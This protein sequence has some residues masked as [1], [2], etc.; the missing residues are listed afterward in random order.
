MQ[1]PALKLRIRVIL[2]IVAAVAIAIVVTKKVDGLYR[3]YF[4]AR[5]LD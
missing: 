5:F 3:R 4:V 2:F 1:R